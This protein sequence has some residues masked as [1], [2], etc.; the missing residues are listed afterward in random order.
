MTVLLDKIWFANGVAISPDEDFLVVAETFASKLIKIWLTGQ[1]KGKSETFFTGI[2]GAPDNLTFDDQGIWV[3]LAAVITDKH[4]MIPHFLTDYPMARKFLGRLFELFK[5]PSTFINGIYPN[6]ITHAVLREF[7]STDTI[8][9]ITPAFRA[10]VRLNWNGHVV[11]FYHGSDETAGSVTH[12]MEQDG[13]LYLGS[14]TSQFIAR[15]R[16]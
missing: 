3:A 9:Y 11:K 7:Y 8:Q 5:M 10:V 12:A 2:P 6:S 13:F 15:V 1:K 16:I 4:P 14:V